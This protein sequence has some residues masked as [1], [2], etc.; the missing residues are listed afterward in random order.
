[1]RTLSLAL[2]FH[3]QHTLSF[4]DQKLNFIRHNSCNPRDWAMVL[5]VIRSSIFA[6]V[7]IVI[8]DHFYSNESCVSTVCERKY[9]FLW[10][11]YLLCCCLHF[12]VYYIIMRTIISFCVYILLLIFCCTF[13]LR[14]QNY[15]IKDGHLEIQAGFKNKVSCDKVD[16]SWIT[17]VNT[18]YLSTK[19]KSVQHPL[20]ENK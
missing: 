15:N 4:I 8:I 6:C 12:Y 13:F 18:Y 14:Y 9:I 2:F 1:M 10:P 11:N 17:S 3:N 20:L 16:V 7:A 5:L 19:W